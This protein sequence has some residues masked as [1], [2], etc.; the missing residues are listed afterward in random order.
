[1]TEKKV[2]KKRVAKKRVATRK[3]PEK[4]VFEML[5]DSMIGQP[6]VIA[7]KVFLA[8]LGLVSTIQTEVSDKF[9]EL[10]KDGE[11]ARDKY[12][13]SFRKFQKGLGS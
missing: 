9:D 2:A 6:F 11:K 10:V 4:S 5:E 3:K 7:N 8:S 1:M 12:Q 13:A